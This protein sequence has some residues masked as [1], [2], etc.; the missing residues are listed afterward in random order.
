MLVY[1]LGG[2]TYMEIAALRFLSEKPECELLL[3]VVVVLI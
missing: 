2:V 1:Y 3:F